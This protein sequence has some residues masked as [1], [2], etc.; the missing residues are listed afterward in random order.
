MI[1]CVCNFGVFMQSV[2]F[3]PYR[4]LYT[5]PLEATMPLVALSASILVLPCPTVVKV[6]AVVANILLPSIGFFNAYACGVR[7]RQEKSREKQAAE[8]AYIDTV[9]RQT[10]D[11]KK[12]KQKFREINSLF[13]EQ[14]AAL[15]DLNTLLKLTS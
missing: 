8:L 5:H 14:N 15:R 3:C 9:V 11:V 10:E 7:Q 4:V 6:I 13:N 1:L 2:G 12:F